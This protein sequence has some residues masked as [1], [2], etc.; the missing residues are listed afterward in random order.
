MLWVRTPFMTRC[1]RY[2]IMWCSLSVTY[3]RLGGFLLVLHQ[4]NWLPRYIWNIIESGVK[5]HQL[6]LS[7]PRQ[8][9]WYVPYKQFIFCDCMM[10]FVIL[11]TIYRLEQA[12]IITLY[13]ERILLG[14]IKCFYFRK[15]LKNQLN[16]TGV[17]F[18]ADNFSLF[19]I[20]W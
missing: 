2:N 14:C 1:T 5:H 18:S 13:P 9:N 19:S 8:N 10:Y 17:R 12:T 15:H 20:R 7:P 4:Y 6:N 11:Y 3:D 16:S